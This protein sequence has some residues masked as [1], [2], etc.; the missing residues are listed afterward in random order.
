MLAS[1]TNQ[2]INLELSNKNPIEVGQIVDMDI[3]YNT[4]V[5]PIEKSE[6]K[7]NRSLDRFKVFTD[8]SK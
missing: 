6:K 8:D 3:K 1:K 7:K 2:L 4:V 5:K